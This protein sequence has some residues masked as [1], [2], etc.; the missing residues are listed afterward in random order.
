MRLET[1]R[2]LL[3][4]RVSVIEDLGPSLFCRPLFRLKCCLEAYY[5]YVVLS[6]SDQDTII[7]TT[8]VFPSLFLA[9]DTV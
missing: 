3:C 1:Y 8:P 9:G 6:Y 5:L 4:V 7:F 2:D